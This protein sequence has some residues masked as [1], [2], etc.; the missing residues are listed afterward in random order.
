M[1]MQ[2]T[3]RQQKSGSRSDRAITLYL[4][5]GSDCGRRRCRYTLTNIDADHGDR[6]VVGL[7]SHGVLLVFAAPS[8]LLSLAGREHGRTI[9]LTDILNMLKVARLA[10]H[11]LGGL[12]ASA[13]TMSISLTH[14]A[15]ARLWNG[16]LLYERLRQLRARYGQSSFH[17]MEP[18]ATFGSCAKHFSPL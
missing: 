8:Q 1:A 11:Q 12:L 4:A 18:L 14:T 10:L 3:H 9:P 16:M 13:L 17:W 7:L 5:C 6:A 15:K 2:I